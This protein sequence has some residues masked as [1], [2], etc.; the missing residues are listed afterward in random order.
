MTEREKAIVDAKAAYRLLM[1]RGIDAGLD[2]QP[3]GY[4]WYTKSWVVRLN[5]AGMLMSVT[6]RKG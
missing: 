5:D 2:I 3:D 1:T 6:Q 4:V